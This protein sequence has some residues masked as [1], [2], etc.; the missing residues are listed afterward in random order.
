MTIAF[1]SMFRDFVAAF[2]GDVVPGDPTAK[3]TN[4]WFKMTNNKQANK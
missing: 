2:D 1:E 4:Y 3:T